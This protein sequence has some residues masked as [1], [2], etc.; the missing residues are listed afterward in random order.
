MITVSNPDYVVFILSYKRAN[1][2]KTY[3]TLKRQ[4]YKGRIFIIVGDDD[5]QINDY[6]R[7]YGEQV[8]VFSK[9]DYLHVDTG[10]NKTALNTVLFARNACYDLAKQIGVRYFLQLDD[11]YIAFY[12]KFIADDWYKAV[13]VL[14]LQGIFDACFTYLAETPTL[15]CLALAQAGDFV[16]GKLVPQRFKRKAMNSFFCDT[17]RRIH[18]ISRMNDDV[19]TYVTGGSRG[20][21]YLTTYRASLTQEP[22]QSQEGGLTEMYLENG[23]YAKSFYTVMMHPS[24]VKIKIHGGRLHHH[25]PSGTTYPRIL[26]ER[27]KR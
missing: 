20:E 4:G 9:A 12:Y 22:T 14:N 7:L 25:V 1:N 23:T 13:R 5:P 19:S 18:F 10:D 11:D 21:L 27:Y 6:K 17:E 24:S 16:G 26:S 2:V 8:L 3:N 15:K